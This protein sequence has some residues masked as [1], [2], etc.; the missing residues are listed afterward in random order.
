MRRLFLFMGIMFL[1]QFVH[2]EE[3][4]YTDSWGKAGLSLISSSTSG[5]EANFSI[6]EFKINDLIR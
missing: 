5:V 3:I 4:R 2:A 1:I 6:T